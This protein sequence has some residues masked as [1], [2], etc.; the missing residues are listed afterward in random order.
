M[1]VVVGLGNPG[2]E[3][4]KT[5]HNVGFRV[6]AELASRHGGAKPRSNF[7][8]E[9]VDI[10]LAGEKT[11]LVA[12]MTYMNLSG[13]SVRQLVDFYKLPLDDMLVVCDD[14][15]LETARLR[16]RRSGSA[17]GQKGLGDIMTRLGTE[18][19]ARLRIGID[20]PPGRMSSTDYVLGKFRKEEVEPIEHAV[21][22][23]ADAVELWIREGI[24]TAMNRVN[25]PQ[26]D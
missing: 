5:R 3:Y 18:D 8:A 1:K 19:F 26:P 15:N 17:G 24:V 6:V 14:M 20:R 7:E 11:L 2:Q 25:A 10:V 21:I 13:R 4:Q 16:L 22:L 9:V 23:A 12:P